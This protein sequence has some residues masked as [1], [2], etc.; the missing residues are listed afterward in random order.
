MTVR[1]KS[2]TGLDKIKFEKQVIFFY[3]FVTVN[4]EYRAYRIE[5]TIKTDDTDIHLLRELIQS[6]DFS[7]KS[8]FKS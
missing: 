6:L 2:D 5:F 3:P 4:G 7:G 8:P 1:D